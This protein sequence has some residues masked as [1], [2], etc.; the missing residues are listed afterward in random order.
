MKSEKLEVRNQKREFRKECI[1]VG[2][3]LLF[4]FLVSLF[5]FMPLAAAD[6]DPKPGQS[7]PPVRL[8]KKSKPGE[9][10]DKDKKPQSPKKEQAGKEDKEGDEPAVEPEQDPKEIIGRISKNID[11]TKA[12]LAQKDTGDGTQQLQRDI[13]K[14]LDALIE[15]SNRQQQQQQQQQ[16]QQDQGGQSSNSRQQ[17]NQQAS[18]RRNS[19]QQTRQASSQKTAQ[20]GQAKQQAQQQANGQKPGAGGAG[21]KKSDAPNADLYKDIWGHLPETLR[22]EMDAYARVEFM[23]KYNDLLQQYYSRLS[24]KGRAKGD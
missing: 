2:I 3:G 21:G 23:S 5:W 14:D 9:D 4:W 24:E 11:S 10:L 22:K 17:R 12:R 19:S 20:S 1:A 8:K 18:Q 15:Q 13:V 6:D 16:D 7:E